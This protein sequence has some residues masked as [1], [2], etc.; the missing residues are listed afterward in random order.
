[1]ILS[2]SLDKH[3]FDS[4][5][6]LSPYVARYAHLSVQDFSDT[7]PSLPPD[8]LQNFMA[9]MREARQIGDQ[10]ADVPNGGNMPAPREVAN[11]NLVAVLLESMLPWVN[12]GTSE[13]GL[14]A[15]AG[16]QINGH[17]DEDH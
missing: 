7:I 1:M 8:N 14:E 3:L 10:A 16:D 6:F 13:D 11:R 9:D 17:G 12:Y 4:C 15:G 2:C 5:I